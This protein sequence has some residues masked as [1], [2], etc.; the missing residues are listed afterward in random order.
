MR[1]V[2]PDG[3]HCLPLPTPHR[4]FRVRLVDPPDRHPEVELVIDDDELCLGWSALAGSWYAVE[5]R[6]SLDQAGWTT[7][8]TVRTVGPDGNHCLPLPTPHRHFRVRLVEPPPV[9]E[10]PD[11]ELLV[12]EDRICLRWTAEAGT[13]YVIEGKRTLDETSWTLIGDAT[14]DTA[15]GEYCLDLPVDWRYLRVRPREEDAQPDHGLGARWQGDRI[16]LLW[17]AQVGRSYAVMGRE[18]LESEWIPVAQVRAQVVEMEH[19]LPPGTPYRYFRVEVG[20]VPSDV[21]HPSIRLENGQLCLD[22][23]AT[24]GAGYRI[25]TTDS[26]DSG[27]W[28]EFRTVEAGA[29]IATECLPM[30]DAVRFYRVIALP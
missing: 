25:E 24:P 19:C 29:A 30:V 16:C 26:L 17:T 9:T 4:H 12:E 8:A 7:L 10:A 20:E 28:A 15:Q 13:R 6:R 18:T 22:W 5:G 23:D 2:G 14:P 21:I 27:T 3:N 1:T 11:P